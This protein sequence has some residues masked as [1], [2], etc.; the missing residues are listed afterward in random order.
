[1]NKRRYNHGYEIYK[2]YSIEE[3]FQTIEEKDSIPDPIV[4]SKKDFNDSR[5]R[6]KILK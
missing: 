3:I 4:Y 6:I 2:E 5:T 1:M